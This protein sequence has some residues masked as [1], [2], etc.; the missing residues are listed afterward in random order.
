MKLTQYGE[1][2]QKKDGLSLR[3]TRDIS[4]NSCLMTL[5][6]FSRKNERCFMFTD[7]KNFCK[8]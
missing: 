6:A 5:K 7:V 3:K 2:D 4:Y 8:V 1:K